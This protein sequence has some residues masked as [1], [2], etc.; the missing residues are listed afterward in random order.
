MARSTSTPGDDSP[1]DLAP[2]T[3]D[4]APAGESDAKRRFREALE[5]KNAKHHASAAA[6]ESGDSKVHSAHG[7]AAQQKQ[8][9]RKS[10]G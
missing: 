7:P 5:R 8:F 6:G 3:G 10:G 2:E 9:R 1:E 4:A